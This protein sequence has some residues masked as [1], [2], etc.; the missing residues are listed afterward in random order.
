MTDR[1]PTRCTGYRNDR[2][3]IEHDGPTCPV[4]EGPQVGP[5]PVP[6]NASRDYRLIRMG[7]R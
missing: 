6:A 1:I 2:N 3:R 7:L 5:Q 4:H